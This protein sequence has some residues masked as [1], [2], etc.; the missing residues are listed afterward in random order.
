VTLPVARYGGTERIMWWLGK[1]LARR[2]HEVTYLIKGGASPFARVVAVDIGR[3]LVSQ[4]PADADV[5][6]FHHDLPPGEAPP[7]PYVI[8]LHG[9]GSREEELD[10]N[11]V[12]ISAS[13]ARRF[14]SKTV[15][16]NGVDWEEYGPAELDRPRTWC[17]FLGDA[18]WKVKNVRGAIRVA[19]LARTPLHVL[20]GFRLNFRMG[21]RL[22]L[23]PNVKFHGWVGMEEKRRFLPGSRGLVFP[24][25]WHEPFG[26]AIV[27][28][29]YHGCPVYGTPYGALPEIVGSGYGFLSAD[30]HELADALR[31]GQGLDPRACH[32]HA[33]ERFGSAA[34][35][36]GYLRA[37]ERVAAGEPL[38]AAPP[39]RQVPPDTGLLP[40]T[41]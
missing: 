25:R 5:V 35:A 4:V 2:G 31:R 8:T 32:A 27:E 21:F 3:P 40:F 6:H 28:S 18:G 11:T 36:D 39:R 19:A 38:H 16:H 9:R 22:T 34:M 12:F 13:Q 20:G 29:L 41:F 15:V 26:L 37:Y 14:G 7:R 23:S 17:H 1:E 33:V 10:R 24:V 30:A